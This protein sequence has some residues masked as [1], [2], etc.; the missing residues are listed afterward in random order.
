MTPTV[1]LAGGIAADVMIIAPI[2]SPCVDRGLIE[3]SRFICE[4]KCAKRTKH[5]S[6]CATMVPLVMTTF[7]SWV[8]L[9]RNSCR[10]SLMLHAL[11]VS[12][13]EVGALGLPCSTVLWLC[14]RSG[15]WHLSYLYDTAVLEL[16]C[17]TL[18]GS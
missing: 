17:L 10:A 18:F 3:V 13:I 1:D 9:L 7:A 12:Q 16:F 2:A 4:S 11:L 14:F 5:A 15:A 8:L 6:N